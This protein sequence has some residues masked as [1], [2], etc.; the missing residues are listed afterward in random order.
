[1]ALT[2]LYQGIRT[3]LVRRRQNLHYR[4]QRGLY[5]PL[6]FYWLL[7]GKSRSMALSQKSAMVF[8]PHQDDETLGCGGLIT[9]KLEQGLSVWV[10]F[11]T[12]GQK[13]Q[14]SSA[15]Q[16][17]LKPEELVQIRKQEALSALTTL[18]VEASQVYFL[19]QP[20]GGLSRLLPAAQQQALEQ[21][22]QL[23][24]QHAPQEIYVPYQ[25][26]GHP[27]HEATYAIVQAAL[28]AAQLPSE[29]LQYPV[30]SLWNP[31]LFD[32]RSQELAHVYRLPLGR[33]LPRKR[34]ALQAYRSQYLPPAPGAATPLPSGFF[35]RFLSP[36]EIFFRPGVK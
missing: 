16:P 9:L 28:T 19:D 35:Q 5:S 22:V 31:W 33:G 27:D 20:D 7:Y 23:L 13:G 34:Q 1:M 12:D 30:W 14:R 8:A 11:L 6:F 25:K 3:A 4:L 18:G 24:Q 17:K 10:V 2:Q 26:D 36:Y 21:L 32:L 29:L 15:Q